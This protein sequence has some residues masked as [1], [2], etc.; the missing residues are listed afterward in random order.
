MV[1]PATEGLSK[2]V[3]WNN[4]FPFEPVSSFV[5]IA[6]ASFWFSWCVTAFPVRDSF[7]GKWTSAVQGDFVIFWQRTIDLSHFTF[8]SSKAFDWVFPILWNDAREAEAFLL[9]IPTRFSFERNFYQ[10]RKEGPLPVSEIK[11]LMSD[12]WQQNY[13]SSLSDT[14]PMFWASKLHFHIAGTSFYN[15]PYTFGYLFS[16]GVFAQRKDL[17][18]GFY[19]AYVELLRDTGRMTV[20]EVAKK[21]L[22][23]D[24][25]KDDFWRNSLGIVERKVSKFRDF[26]LDL[27]QQS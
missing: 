18:D 9:N 10:K 1:T 27:T 6:F 26:A 19:K 7:A 24:L 2:G 4:V 25:G 20:E 11:E 17:G 8:S 14:N 5:F 22:N 23:V 21:H 12:A 16:L 3:G 13:G 15:F